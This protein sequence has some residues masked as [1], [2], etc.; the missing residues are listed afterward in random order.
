MAGAHDPVAEGDAAN[1]EW[2]EEWIGHGLL[3]GWRTRPIAG[4][5]GPEGK[6]QY[7]LPSAATAHPF[8]LEDIQDRSDDDRDAGP[9]NVIWEITEQP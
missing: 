5:I 1:A 2:R 4:W 6:P 9:L 3:P 8:S 7:Q